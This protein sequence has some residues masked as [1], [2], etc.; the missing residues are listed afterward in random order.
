MLLSPLLQK[1]T[2]AALVLPVCVLANS[3]Y[4]DCSP[5]KTLEASPADERGGFVLELD[6][7]AGSRN[8]RFA[9]EA[10]QESAEGRLSR[11]A[12]YGEATPIAIFDL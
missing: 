7:P 6:Q 5:G 3:S 11:R 9:V 10:L 12:F 4:A 8:S 2:T 1:I